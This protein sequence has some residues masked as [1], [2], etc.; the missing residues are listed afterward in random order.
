LQINNNYNILNIDNN[1]VNII[2]MKY[3]IS[4]YKSIYC[5]IEIYYKI[6]VTFNNI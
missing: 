5:Y 1:I 2:K 3:L 6:L 4:T